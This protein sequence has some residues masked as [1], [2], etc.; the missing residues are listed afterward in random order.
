VIK[1]S[2]IMLEVPEQLQ[3]IIR[4]QLPISLEK[5]WSEAVRAGA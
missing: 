3:D 5:V 2:N 1:V 4:H